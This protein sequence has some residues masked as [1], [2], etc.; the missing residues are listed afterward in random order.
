MRAKSVNCPSVLWACFACS[1]AWTCLLADLND[2]RL[3][4]FLTIPVIIYIQK[5]AAFVR[6]GFVGYGHY[7]RIMQMHVDDFL[8]CSPNILNFD[9]SLM[10]APKASH[11]QVKIYFVCT[12]KL[13]ARHSS[14]RF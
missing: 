11:S 6:M 13:L 7:G 12:V 4:R 1:S 9:G 5:M 3:S 14:T 2:L 8:G 10:L